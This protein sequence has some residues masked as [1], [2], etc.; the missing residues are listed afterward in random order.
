LAW[1]KF[2][3]KCF[4]VNVVGVEGEVFFVVVDDYIC[5]TA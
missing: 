2:R 1:P 3:A 5:F 4:G